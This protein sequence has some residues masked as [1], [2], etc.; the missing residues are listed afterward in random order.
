MNT[1]YISEIL[2]N[3]STKNVARAKI[4]VVDDEP[5]IRYVV[6][7]ILEEEG[8]YIDEAG[9]GEEALKKLTHSSYDL[10]IVDLVMPHMD[11]FEFLEKA[12]NIQ[13]DLITVIITAYGSQSVAIRAIKEG[14]YDYFTKPFDNDELRIVIRR[15]LEKRRLEE[16]VKLLE[17]QLLKQSLQFGDLIGS[18]AEMREVFSL[19][20]KV[21]KSDVT[22][23]IY[24]ESGTGKELVARAI[25]KESLRADKPFVKVNCAAIPE[26]LLESELFGYV[27]GAFTGAYSK[28]TGK[29][30]AANM[31]TIFLDE[32]G[33]MPLSIQSK[34]LRILEQ[35][36][37]EP[38]GSNETTKVDVRIIAATNKDLAAKVKE[39]TFR[40][41]LFFRINVVPVYLPPLR[42]RTSDIPLL[43]DY[44]INLYKK[45]LDKNIKGVTSEVMEIFKQYPWPGNVRELEN[46]I[47]R[48]LIMCTSDFITPDCLPAEFK[49]PTPFSGFISAEIFNDFSRP[50]TAKIQTFSEQLEKELIKRA[51][52]KTN[53]KRKKTAELLGIS[54]K[55]LHNKMLKYKLF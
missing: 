31:G 40:E 46:V 14:A 43:V 15:V 54:R 17:E 27:R 30:E 22:V 51:L 42:Q 19:I 21:S 1:K 7:E 41:D 2:G 38:L 23:L 55:S 4:L 48:A 49:T 47:Q 34:V 37:F 25:H 50:L 11:G 10:A 53:Y 39:G 5:G 24:G 36:E 32:I 16:K 3:W 6:R 52:E 26:T 45:T 33:D 18:S 9:D 29:F 20:R 8:F 13:P 28:K 44:F 35:R 12:R